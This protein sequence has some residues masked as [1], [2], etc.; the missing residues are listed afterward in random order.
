MAYR[1][2]SVHVYMLP[3]L[4]AP[5]EK[6]LKYL[7]VADLASCEKSCNDEAKCQSITFWKHGA[8]NC[9]HFETKCLYRQPQSMAIAKS[10]K[11]DMPK[12]GK[13]SV[14]HVDKEKSDFCRSPNAVCDCSYRCKPGYNFIADEKKSGK[15]SGM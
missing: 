15:C 8:K 14:Y 13:N 5:R 10:L 11:L 9:N 1:E 7:K 3:T 6:P 2:I 4:G 12:S